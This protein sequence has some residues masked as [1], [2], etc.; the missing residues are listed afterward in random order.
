[1]QKQRKL[2][3]HTYIQCGTELTDIFQ[4]A[5]LQLV[6]GQ[7]AQS[8]HPRSDDVPF[9]NLFRKWI[10]A[11]CSMS[12]SNKEHVHGLYIHRTRW[13]QISCYEGIIERKCM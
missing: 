2:N 9:Q 10:G 3:K 8:A 7:R 5:L 1:M 4:N 13:S 6:G 11:V 12:M